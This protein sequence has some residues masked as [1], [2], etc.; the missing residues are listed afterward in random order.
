MNLIREV[1]DVP[2]RTMQGMQGKGPAT[3]EKI[4]GLVIPN[5]RIQLGTRPEEL[6][7]NS[8]YSVLND[9]YSALLN[10]RGFTELSAAYVDVDFFLPDQKM[11]VE[12]DESQ[13]FT[14]PRKIALS[15]YPSDLNIR[16]SRD[17]WMKHCDDIQAYDNDPPYRDEQRAWYDTLRDFIPEIKGFRPMARDSQGTWHGA[18]L[19]QIM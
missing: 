19:T 13:H 6:R 8:R 1:P 7:E 15:H 14:K 5:Y 11:I 12:F 17:T 18:V 2:Q 4:Y 10:H 9:I 16:F 3:L